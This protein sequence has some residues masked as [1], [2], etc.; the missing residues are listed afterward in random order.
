MAAVERR[1]VVVVVAAAAAARAAAEGEG[2]A[3]AAMETPEVM[4]AERGT[5]RQRSSPIAPPVS[6]Y[7]TCAF[8]L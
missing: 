4:G 2:A 6:S 7:S 8:R 1:V 5:A 3:A